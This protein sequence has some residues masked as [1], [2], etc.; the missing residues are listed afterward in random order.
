MSVKLSPD[1]INKYFPVM[2]IAVNKRT[3]AA[4]VMRKGGLGG[5][6]LP[7]N[8]GNRKVI[9]CL[10]PSSLKELMFIATNT[11]STFLSLL[12]L[13]YLSPPIASQSKVDLNRFLVFL[14]RKTEIPLKYLWFMEF[15]ARGAI[16]YHLLLNQMYQERLH[17]SIADY[18]AR[19]IEPWNVGYSSLLDRK[20]RMTQDTVAMVHKDKRGVWENVREQNGMVRY[21]SKYAMKKEQKSP[22]FWMNLTGRFWGCDRETGK[23]DWS[24]FDVKPINETTL[25]MILEEQ[26][27]KTKD[28]DVIPKFLFNFET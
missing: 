23:I 17:I 7:Q 1:T 25:R 18:W 24:E 10:S 13:T 27:H 14:K 5:T 26:Q 9:R 15:Q 3:R 22:P 21:L 2:A 16:H 28:F 6:L 20:Q 12:T 11:R 19:C 4:K 8:S